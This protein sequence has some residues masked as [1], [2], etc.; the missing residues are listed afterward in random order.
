M[1]PIFDGLRDLHFAGVLLRLAMA[2]LC[3]G[4]I[5]LER[6]F[7]GRS[8]G[9]RIHV[10]L[11]IGGAV[12][13]MTGL[14]L[15]VGAGLPADV[16]RIGAQLVSG[17]G[18]IGAGTIMVTKHRTVHGLTTAAGL[19]LS[20]VIGLAIGAGYYEGGVLATLLAL[21]VTLI[22]PVL[23]QSVPTGERHTLALRYAERSALRKAMHTCNEFGAQLAS[24]EL[25]T[26]GE[27]ATLRY[28][29]RF[30][31]SPLRTEEMEKLMMLL[32]AIPGMEEVR[33][34]DASEHWG[35]SQRQ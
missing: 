35:E 30:E 15:Y 29:A 8:A 25:R 22:Y 12:A 11:C 19:W 10:L 6:S 33:Q 20:G 14:Y 27:G 31:M 2:L 5:G 32:R 9:V 4:A 17:L 1:L 13:S 24:F 23:R 18:F 26:D 16:S 21:I 28:A 3:G 34:L 7:R